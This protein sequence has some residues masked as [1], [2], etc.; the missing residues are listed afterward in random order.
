MSIDV[1]GTAVVIW[2]YAVGVLMGWALAR[3]FRRAERTEKKECTSSTT[4]GKS[5]T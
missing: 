2:T 1:T 5:D 3:A 4:G